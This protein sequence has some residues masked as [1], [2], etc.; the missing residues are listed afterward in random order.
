[1]AQ[2]TFNGSRAKVYVDDVL[3]GLYDSIQHGGALGTEAIH[4]LGRYSPDEIAITSYEAIQVSCSGFRVI[5][6]GVHVL[7]K[8]PK[9]QDLLQF[10][11]IKLSIVDRQTGEETAVIRNCVPANWGEGNQAKATTKFNITY[12]G[13]ILTDESG[14]QDESAGATSLP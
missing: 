10:E 5:G 2:K 12:V 7:P 4:L 14:D 11:T 9:L 3:V 1:M 8:V 13:T 6:Q